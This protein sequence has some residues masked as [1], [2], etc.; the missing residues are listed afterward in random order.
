MPEWRW[1]FNRQQLRPQPIRENPKLYIDLA[2]RSK[3]NL[4]LKARLLGKQRVNA[5]RII[6]QLLN[7]MHDNYN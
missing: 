7:L 1:D 3:L 4:T 6:A 2:I 5:H